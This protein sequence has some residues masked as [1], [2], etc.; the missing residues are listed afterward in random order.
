MKRITIFVIYDAE[1]MIDQYVYRL[2]DDIMKFSDS[3]FVVSNSQISPDAYKLLYKRTSHILIRENKGFDAGAYKDAIA[4]LQRQN[5]LDEFDE[6]VLC[7]DTF[8]GFFYSLD[9]FFSDAESEN[10][11]F[12]GLTKSLGSKPDAD[13][14]VPEHLQSYFM[15]IMPHMFHSKDF[16]DF[17]TNMEYPSDYMDVLVGFEQLF[18]WY[19]AQRGYTYKAYFDVSK[20]ELQQQ[21]AQSVYHDYIYELVTQMRFPLI[22]CKTFFPEE[23]YYDAY[24]ALKFIEDCHA[25]DSKL[26]EE[27]QRRYEQKAYFHIKK[28]LGFCQRY[29]RVYLYGAG[30]Y[31]H[32]LE[33]VLDMNHVVFAGYITTTMGS[34]KD[35]E[36]VYQIEKVKI[37]EDEGIIIAT[38]PEYAKEIYLN[39]ISRIS[40]KQIYVEMGGQMII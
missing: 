1:N 26:V 9:D 21:Y 22:K 6:L 35:S 3:V 13:N 5:I 4:V 40:K 38:K 14:Y 29:K 37:A 8:Y 25:Y 10:T 18:T 34:N 36:N 12:W 28:I 23:N 31:G 11:D 7:N 24:R 17:W 27:H 39:L 15:L 19:F 2:L 20:I 32:K 33:R 16:S 30:R